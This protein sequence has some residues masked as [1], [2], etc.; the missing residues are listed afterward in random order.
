LVSG[1]GDGTVRLWRL[2]DGALLSTV[3]VAEHLARHHVQ[4]QQ[5][6]VT[7]V[8]ASPA[9]V[10]ITIEQ[11]EPAIVALGPFS[12]QLKRLNIQPGDGA[13]AAVARRRGARVR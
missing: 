3:D 4:T 11:Y 8:V 6:V 13:G 12:S 7:H 5:C 10:V 1:S 2:H 9:F